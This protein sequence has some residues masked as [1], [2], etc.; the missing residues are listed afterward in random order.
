MLT[1]NYIEHHLCGAEKIVLVWCKGNQ[2]ELW[3]NSE[4]WEQRFI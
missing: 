2:R 1:Q 3:C 4:S